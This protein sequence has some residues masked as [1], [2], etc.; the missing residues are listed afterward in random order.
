MQLGA[1]P[2]FDD[3]EQLWHSKHAEEIGGSNLPGYKNP[4]VD[5]LIDSLPPIFDAAK[6]NQII[7]QIDSIIYRDMPYVL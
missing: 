1:R 3:P 6:R 4:E 5:R 7:K 2:L